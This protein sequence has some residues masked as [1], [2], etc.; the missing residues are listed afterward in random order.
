MLLQESNFTGR[1]TRRAHITSYRQLRVKDLP[2][3][4]N[5]YTWRLERDSN[6][7]PCASNTTTGPPH[8]HIGS[9]VIQFIAA[10]VFLQAVCFIS[11]PRCTCLAIANPTFLKRRALAN[12]GSTFYKSHERCAIS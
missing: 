11:K 5:N 4:P 12:V 10:H 7:R 3:V 2:K 9:S 6:Q 1:L 8:P